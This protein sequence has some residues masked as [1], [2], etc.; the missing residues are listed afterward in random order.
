MTKTIVIGETHSNRSNK[1]IKFLSVLSSENRAGLEFTLTVLSKPKN[2]NYI[3]LV[4]PKYNG[5]HDIMFAYDYPDDRA[6]GCLFLG[7]WNDGI[8]EG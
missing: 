1:Y 7:Y 4:C 8:V 2:Y 5:T 6:G 3:E